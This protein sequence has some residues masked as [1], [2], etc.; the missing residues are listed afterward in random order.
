MKTHTY[1]FDET[2]AQRAV[3]F[4]NKLYYTDEDTGE[5]K[6]FVLE[7]W[8]EK[9]VKDLFGWVDDTCGKLRYRTAFIF[10]S[11]KNGKTALAGAILLY[12]LFG[13]RKYNIETYSAAAEREQASIIYRYAKDMVESTDALNK[14][15]YCV[16]STKR[17]VFKE[18][19]NY[20]ASLSSDAASKH[21]YNPFITIID[22]LHAHK[23][24]ALYDA[25]SQASAAKEES[26][27]IIITHAGNNINN[28]CFE[29]YEYAKDVA[30]GK[31]KDDTFYPALF[32]I[33]DKELWK[34]EERWY[35]A[36]PGLGT[37]KS[38]SFMRSQ[39]TKALRMK[40][41]E[42]VFKQLHLNLWTQASAETWIDDDTWMQ[43]FDDNIDWDSLRGA[44]VTGGLDLAENKDFSAFVLYFPEHGII[45]PYFW[46]PQ[47]QLDERIEDEHTDL[48]AWQEQGLLKVTDGNIVDHD[49]IEE[50]IKDILSQYETA[51]VAYDRYKATQLV[52]NLGDDGITMLPFGQGF[53]SMNPA[54]QEFE[55]LLTKGRIR[56]DGNRI[57]RWMVSNTVLYMDPAGLIKPDRSK[58]KD[59]IDGLVASVMAVG[60]TLSDYFNEQYEQELKKRNRDLGRSVRSLDEFDDTYADG[61]DD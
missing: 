7:G 37:I 1:V 11:K 35:K 28:A 58:S 8:Q 48:L 38:L 52:L 17:I 42:L 32:E 21:G 45:R 50:D 39:L 61:V 12:C 41:E 29:L 31:V 4:I 26:L 55:R 6:A 16:D 36:N 44:I 54:C 40:S 60:L 27:Q 59:K 15:A 23:S 5:R 53:R 20:Y 51:A 46:I 34:E 10:V 57:L 2:K 3:N 30:S 25:L 14:R 56:H 33:D 18:Q 9:I 13:L 49:V 19:K 24:R 43:G 47:A 22:E